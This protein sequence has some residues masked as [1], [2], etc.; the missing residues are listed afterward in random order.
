MSLSDVFFLQDGQMKKVSTIRRPHL[1]LVGLVLLL[2]YYP[3]NWLRT[4]RLTVQSLIILTTF[5]LQ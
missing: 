2:L 3:E 5:S 1:V 4:A